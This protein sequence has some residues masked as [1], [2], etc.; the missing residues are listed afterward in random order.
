MCVSG[1]I[2]FSRADLGK[3][4]VWTIQFY[5]AGEEWLIIPSW[6]GSK[7]GLVVCEINPNCSEW[8]GW[9]NW[10]FPSSGEILL[11]ATLLLGLWKLFL[12]EYCKLEA[13]TNAVLE[14]KNFS[15]E[16]PNYFSCKK[17][18]SDTRVQRKRM[19]MSAVNEAFSF[20]HKLST[21]LPWKLISPRMCTLSISME[22]TIQVKELLL[23]TIT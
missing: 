9:V 23:Y 14:L 15:T 22:W 2:F 11:S 16:M 3:L 21:I 4:L 20:T 19:H 6:S 18:I 13:Q 1:V 8:L 10:L 17:R 5:L 7:P 12:T